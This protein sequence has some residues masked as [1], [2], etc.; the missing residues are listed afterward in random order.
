MVDSGHIYIYIQ[1]ILTINFM[2]D[3]TLNNRLSK[4]SRWLFGARAP[5][6]TAAKSSGADG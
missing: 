4:N 5:K 2:I 1:Y 6:G 3:E